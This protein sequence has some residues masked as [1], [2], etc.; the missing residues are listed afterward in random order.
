MDKKNL[1]DFMDFVHLP[2]VR[3]K[4]RKDGI[5][6]FADFF[7][8][9]QEVEQFLEVAANAI[10]YAKLIH[11]GL[12]SSVPKGWIEKKL[13]LYKN[14]GVKTYPGGIPF[15]VA[16][17]QNK[18]SEYFTWLMDHGFD[19]VEISYD[20]LPFPEPARRDDTIREALQKGLE[21]ITEIGKKHPDAPMNLQDAYEWIR[22]DV[23]VG[24]SHVTIER[25]EL[26][27]YVNDAA[28]LLD[29]ANKVGLRHLMFEPNPTGWP[30]MHRWCFQTFGHN[31]NLGNIDKDE[32]LYVEW[33]RWGL[34]RLVDFDYFTTPPYN[35]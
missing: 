11:I 20:A 4:P 18:V 28:P 32:V 7:Y 27:V 8:P 26:G 5:T 19:A 31:V 23:A 3:P 30:H 1:R 12:D 13:R 10:D 16:V 24:V 15:E 2:P 17:V 34:S 9:L 33:T 22:H 29:L 6:S 25:G 21:V 35:R 14:K